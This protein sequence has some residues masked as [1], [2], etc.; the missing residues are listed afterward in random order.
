MKIDRR[1]RVGS[2]DD[3][4]QHSLFSILDENTR[5]LLA[6]QCKTLDLEANAT[7]FMQGEKHQYS[8]IIA[9]GLVRTYYLSSSGREVTLGHWSDGDLVGA[10]LIF[11]GGIHVWSCVTTRKAKLL[12]ISGEALR[13]FCEQNKEVYPWIVGVMSFKMLWMSM[14]LQVHGTEQVEHR[15]IKLLLMLGDN[16]GKAEYGVTTISHRISQS[17]L[18][19]LIGASRQ[20]TNKTLN[21]LK[22]RGLIS[23]KDHHIVLQDVAELRAIIEG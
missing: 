7:V 14:L 20:W 17:H 1:I 18:A 6:S 4:R 5:N 21:N 3:L 8:Y 13:E 23:I 16:Y 19:S 11:G 12:A 15:L 9:S 22:Q 10:P 2:H